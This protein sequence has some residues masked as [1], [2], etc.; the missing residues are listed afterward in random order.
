MASTP[1]RDLLGTRDI[2]AARS[3]CED[4]RPEDIN[5][6]NKPPLLPPPLALLLLVPLRLRDSCGLVVDGEVDD[7]AVLDDDA[8]QRVIGKGAGGCESSMYSSECSIVFHT[9]RKF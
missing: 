3:D 2:E 5:L 9:G 6:L 4:D 8:L 7:A 1:L